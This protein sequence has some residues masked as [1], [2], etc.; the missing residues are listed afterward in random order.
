MLYANCIPIKGGKRSIIYDLQRKLYKFIP[1]DLY[2]IVKEQFVNLEELYHAQGTINKP[3]IDDYFE[4]LINM[5]FGVFIRENEKR[6]YPKLDDVFKT[7]SLVKTVVLEIQNSKYINY[8]FIKELEQLGCKYAVLII[9]RKV[10]DIH[11]IL[12]LFNDSGIKAI[13]LFIAYE[14]HLI[15]NLKLLI[16]N[17]QRL[18]SITIFRAKEDYIETNHNPLRQIKYISRDIPPIGEEVSPRKFDFTVNLPFY[19]EALHH[20]PYYN[21]KI[22]IDGKGNISNRYQ[23]KSFGNVNKNKIGDLLSDE[24]KLIWGISKNKIAG[25][26]QCEFR[27]ICLDSRVPVYDESIGEYKFQNECNYDPKTCKWKKY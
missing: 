20:N 13:E 5:E 3:V 19:M 16:E 21:Q 11:A 14:F 18:S 2:E 7:N 22:F 6:F 26:K 23:G 9:N 27:Y 10:K 17:F 24:F 12:S 4:L 15:D 1:N 25:C 8:L